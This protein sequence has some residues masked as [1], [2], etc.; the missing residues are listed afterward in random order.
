MHNGIDSKVELIRQ[1][2]VNRANEINLLLNTHKYTLY[3]AIV[4]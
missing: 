1:F 3:V 2:L 4:C